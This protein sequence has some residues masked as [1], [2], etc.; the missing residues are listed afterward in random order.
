[1]LAQA[2]IG[3]VLAGWFLTKSIDQAVAALFG[4]GVALINGMLIARRIIKTA[5][6]LQP[7]P[8]QEVRSMYIGVIERFVSV[9]VFLALG[10][11]IWQHDRDAQLAL[12]VAFVGGQVALMIFGKTN[13]T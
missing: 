3:V 12:I 10:M 11:M 13:R 7:S 2:L 5:S 6:M 1:M 9:V 4:S 8:A